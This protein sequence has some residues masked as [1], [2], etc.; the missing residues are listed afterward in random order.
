MADASSLGMRPMYP[1]SAERMVAMP[2][3]RSVRKRVL[4]AS[5]PHRRCTSSGGAVVT[6]LGSSQSWSKW[7]KVPW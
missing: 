7:V 5:R 1:W 2:A 3:T 6:K 4:A